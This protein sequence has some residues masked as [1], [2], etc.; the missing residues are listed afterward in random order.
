MNSTEPGR[1]LQTLA[2]RS[3]LNR[4]Y[5]RAADLEAVRKRWE[6][7]AVRLLV[8]TRLALEDGKREVLLDLEVEL[9]GAVAVG[10]PPL[11]PGEGGRA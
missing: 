10:P 5:I 7:L 3:A 6:A 2:L 4:E 9:A 11:L 1:T 8:G